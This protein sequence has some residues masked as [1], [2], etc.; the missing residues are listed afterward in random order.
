[1]NRTTIEDIIRRAA[2][3]TGPLTNSR[4]VQDWLKEHHPK[5]APTAHAIGTYLTNLD[6][7]EPTGRHIVIEPI[8][9]RTVAE[10]RVMGA[11]A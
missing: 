10:F 5:Y 3:A 8:T 2:V 6:I 9:C 7:A 4:K 1:M 11:E